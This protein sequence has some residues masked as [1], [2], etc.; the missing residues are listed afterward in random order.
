[1]TEIWKDVPEYEGLYQVSN[2]G[3]VVSLRKNKILTPK[4]NW[5]GYFRIQLW[6]YNQNVYIGI[7][8]LI[9]EAFIPNPKNKPYINHKNGIKTDNRVENLEWC[10]QLENIKHAIKMGL[11]KPCPK[12]WRV[13]SKPIVQLTLNGEFVKEYPSQMEVERVL[14]INHSN[15]SAACKGKIKTLKGYVWRYAK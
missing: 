15:V 1:M 6:R 10:T 12:N 13:S 5:D 9:A 2:L 8:R 3:R 7:H 11:K 14:G 4:K